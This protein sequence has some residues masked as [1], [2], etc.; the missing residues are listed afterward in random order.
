MRIVARQ[1]QFVILSMTLALV[2][3]GCKGAKEEKGAC[4]E[5]PYDSENA[6][7]RWRPEF[8]RFPLS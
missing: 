7:G 4:P 3:I 6:T 2:L 8:R 1:N 5:A